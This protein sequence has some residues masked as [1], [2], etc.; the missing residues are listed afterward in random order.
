MTI[1]GLWCPSCAA[2]TERLLRDT[3]GVQ[4]AQVSFLGSA[5]MLRWDPERI[6]L[7]QIAEK[8]RRLGY[9]LAPPRSERT[10]RSRLDEQVRALG[11]RLTVAGFFGVWTM[12]FS[13]LLYLG[14]GQASGETTGWWLALASASFALP[15]LGIAGLPVFVAG[16]RTL[17]TGIPGMDTLVTLGVL[18]AAGLSIWQLGQG[19]HHVYTD[20]AVMLVVLLTLGRL[21]ETLALRR[22]ATTIDALHARMPERAER[23]TAEGAIETVPAET[24]AI[25]EHMRVPAGQRIPLD[26]VIEDG[27]TRLDRS[28]MT[29]ESRPATAHPG[30]KVLAGSVNLESAITIRVE[31]TV[32]ERSIDRIGER[33]IEAVRS[34]PGTQRI[35]DRFARWIAPTAI[36]LATLSAL[37]AWLLGLSPEESLLR[38]TSVLVIA[39]PC[40]LSI[41]VPIAYVSLAGRA[42]NEG[43]LFRDAAA[44]EQ[45]ADVD[46]LYLDKTGTL[47]Q[48]RPAVTDVMVRGQL[49]GKRRTDA[50]TVL[51]IAAAAE[52]GVDHVIADALR[53]AAGDTPM[54]A[55]EARRHAA[56]VSASHPDWGQVLVGSPRLLR[57]H[58][59][60]IEPTPGDDLQ[61]EV[62]INDQWVA[63][64]VFDDPLRDSATTTI[65]QLQQAGI[66]CGLITGDRR[67][68]AMRIATAVGLAPSDVRSDCLPD[69]KAKLVR[70]TAG[71]VAFVGDGANDALALASADVGIAVANANSTAAMAADVVL[72]NDGVAGVSRA[73]DL[74][75]QGRRMMRQ[76]LGFAVAYNGI[77][78]TLAVA[79]AIQPVIA[80]TAMAASS[81]TVILNAAR[82]GRSL[83]SPTGHS[84]PSHP[85]V[86]PITG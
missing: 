45:L 50:A 84:P 58:D 25:G 48:G 38:A 83:A 62:A 15:V 42:A 11:I 8:V 43:I 14:V 26:G 34:R 40:A 86:A 74:A 36:G 41:A 28:V 17:R 7:A 21:L 9:R 68:P 31:A 30:D 78:L 56:G 71:P 46:T 63:T 80:A 77:G 47:T 12:L 70:A 44:L 4:E 29:G 13:L 72:G 59:V 19:S 24:I 57:D 33:V 23:L 32:G 79:G 75:R 49:P 82:F 66:T 10:T 35:A 85:D 65:R 64:I 69:D 53:R 22:A 54:P 3:P 18:A 37:A 1:E 76:N 67:V 2:A 61:V 16:W 55:M 52:N 60:Q 20:T 39:C 6:S 81:L 5:A 27:E 73:I 51:Q